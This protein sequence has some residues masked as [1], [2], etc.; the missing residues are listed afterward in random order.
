MLSVDMES[1]ENY[2][3]QLSESVVFLNEDRAKQ[4]DF[5]G[6]IIDKF[7]QS[8]SEIYG[9]P[10][11]DALF[12]VIMKGVNATALVGLP[13]I[14]LF[15]EAFSVFA[16]HAI[17]CYRFDHHLSALQMLEMKKGR[18]GCTLAAFRFKGR[19]AYVGIA[20]D[21]ISQRLSDLPT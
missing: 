16:F 3:L 10:H 2:R 9:L 11:F 5:R 8:R 15:A 6:R 21:T 7:S 18:S 12:A 13:Y 17:F 4:A 20:N 1:L 14:W 19:P